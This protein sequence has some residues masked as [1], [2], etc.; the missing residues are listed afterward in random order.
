TPEPYAPLHATRPRPIPPGC[1]PSAQS[2]TAVWPPPHVPR[3]GG[4]TSSLPEFFPPPRE[5]NPPHG[6]PEAVPLPAHLA[7]NRSIHPPSRRRAAVV[8]AHVGPAFCV[9]QTAHGI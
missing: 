5:G 6:K 9:F 3:R 1:R 4:G 2:H 8:R 7:G